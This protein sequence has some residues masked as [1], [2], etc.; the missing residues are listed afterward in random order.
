MLYLCD[1]RACEKCFPECHHTKDI[2][3][4]RNFQL[5][6]DGETWVESSQ[7][8]ALLEVT[9]ILNQRDMQKMR[10][11]IDEQIP[12]G[13]VLLPIGIKPVIISND[14]SEHPVKFYNYGDDLSFAK[15]KKLHPELS[16]E[17]IRE[18]FWNNEF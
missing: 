10:D 16:E 7:A 11:R 13:V 12:T 8:L 18:R 1:R 5:A 17:E 2:T 6:F 4:A 14:G 15:F 9:T 3:H